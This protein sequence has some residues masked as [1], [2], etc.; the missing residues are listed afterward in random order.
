MTDISMELLQWSIT[1][2]GATKNDNI[3]NKKL[4]EELHKPII[5]KIKKRRVYSTFIDKILGSDI[6]DMQLIRIFNK[7]IR[8]F[9]CYWY[10]SKYARVIALKDK[11]G[12]TITNAFQEIS[13]ESNHKPNNVTR[14]T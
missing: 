6:V 14:F 10:F 7:R 8:F 13:Y 1:S 5:W 11:E 12:T 4:S 9:W 2:G 3:S